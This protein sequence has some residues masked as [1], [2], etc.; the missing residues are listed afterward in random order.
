MKKIL[1]LIIVANLIATPSFALKLITNIETD[2]TVPSRSSQYDSSM[3]DEE[4]ELYLLEQ[5]R[6]QN[7]A[8]NEVQRKY[9]YTDVGWLYDSSRNEVVGGRWLYPGVKNDQ[10]NDN[11]NS[12]KSKKTKTSKT[13]KTKFSKKNKGYIREAADYYT[14]EVVK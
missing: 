9:K 3:T 11:L 4:Y 10:T 8:Q 7:K 5:E 13:S 6:E 1:L 14:I 2:R 12:S